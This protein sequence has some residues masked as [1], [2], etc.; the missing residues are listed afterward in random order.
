M[1][2]HITSIASATLIAGAVLF[3]QVAR[4]Q[5]SEN[6][7][8]RSAAIASKEGGVH[9]GGGDTKTERRIKDIRDDVSA[10]IEKGGAKA[11]R[12]EN[13]LTYDDYIFGNNDKNVYGMNDILVP[14]AVVVNAIK[15]NEQRMDDEEL[16]T[17]VDGKPKTCKGLISARDQRPHMICEVERFADLTE[18]EQYQQIHHEY[19]SLGMLE[20]NVGSDSDY[21]ISKQLTSYLVTETVLRLAVKAPE[22]HSIGGVVWVKMKEVPYYARNGK[23]FYQREYYAFEA[24]KENAKDACKSLGFTDYVTY[25]S[26]DYRIGSANPVNTLDPMSI[27]GLDNYPNPSDS[28]DSDLKY[29]VINRIISKQGLL[30]ET[31]LEGR[32]GRNGIVVGKAIRDLVCM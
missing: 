10:W 18:S 32:T 20:K 6:P 13:S 28:K 19:A 21:S 24:T 22:T 8:K 11:L 1:K 31:R 9:G 23:R 3:T 25:G 17:Y 5:D 4:A 30:D 27:R 2:N 12:F 14:G 7:F 15:A 29:G 16:N 26:Q